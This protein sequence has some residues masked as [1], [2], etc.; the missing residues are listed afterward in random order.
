ME[1]LVRS[2]LGRAREGLCPLRST[3]QRATRV[4]LV[5]YILFLNDKRG[6]KKDA[7]I[8]SF[9][10]IFGDSGLFLR[11]RRKLSYAY[12]IVPPT[13]FELVFWP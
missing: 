10:C 13:R 12:V 7:K 11:K 5:F 1:V 4:E 8:T 3:L 2:R 6:T 9:L